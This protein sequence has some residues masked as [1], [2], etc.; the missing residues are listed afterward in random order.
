MILNAGQSEVE[1][2]QQGGIV[3]RWQVEETHVLFP[4]QVVHTLSG[5]LKRRGG[6]FWAFPNFGHTPTP[7]AFQNLK[8]HGFLRD[9]WSF[10]IKRPKE[11]D[12]V[13]KFKPTQGTFDV[14]PYN[15]F[16]QTRVTLQSDSIEMRLTVNNLSDTKLLPANPGVHPYWSTPY[17]EAFI[18]AGHQTAS[19]HG[20]ICEGK[21]LSSNPMF[22]Q[23]AKKVYVR[24]PGLGHLTLFPEDSLLEKDAVIVVWTDDPRYLAIE[25]V[26]TDV[27][28]FA[29]HPSGWILP[30]KNK[31]F[32]LKA[33]F[34]AK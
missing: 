24:I 9:S 23:M 10:E 4:Q 25:F 18:V 19:V 26:N 2:S 15:F 21:H 17:G 6:S 5:G 16:S 31:T 12:V 8:Q 33:M 7:E 14:F 1:V 28:N 22:L 11:G 29:I 3:T 30:E 13:H 27:E 34:S 32:S 20:G